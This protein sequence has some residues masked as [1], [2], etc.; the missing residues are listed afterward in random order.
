[1]GSQQFTTRNLRFYNA[2]EAIEQVWDWGWTYKSLH[3]GNC[4]VGLN[5]T[6]VNPAAQ[7]VGSIVLLDSF[8]ANTPTGIATSHDSKHWSVSNGSL[9]LEN[10][11]FENVQLAVQGTQGWTALPTNSGNLHV[12][13]WGIGHQYAE[14]GPQDFLGTLPAVS[15]IASLTAGSD[16]GSYYER[17]KP[18]YR[19]V[20]VSDFLSVKT[21]GAEGDGVTDDTEALQAV[22]DQAGS[23]E[24]H[25]AFFDAGTYRVTKTLRVPKVCRIVG[26]SYATIM[27]SGHFFANMTDP[28]AVVQV[29]SPSDVGKV[30]WSDMI[31][32]TQGSQAGAILIEWNVASTGQ[33]SGMWDVHTRIGGFAGSK[34]SVAECGASL[35]SSV[36]SSSGNNT[37]NRREAALGPKFNVGFPVYE[38]VATPT[39][40]ASLGSSAPQLSFTASQDLLQ[41][42]SAVSPDTLMSDS[43]VASVDAAPTID[44]A[45]S[46]YLP[47]QVTLAPLPSLAPIATPLATADLGSVAS[48]T[49]LSVS[50]PIV[51]ATASASPALLTPSSPSPDLSSPY[52]LTS[53][54]PLDDSSLPTNL[55]SNVSSIPSEACIGA[56]M[57][58]HITKSA[59][60]LYMENVW[61]WTADH[62]LDAPLQNI[63]VWSGRGLL[64]ESEKGDVWMYVLLADL[65]Y[66]C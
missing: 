38:G 22:L 52:N 50:T 5:M 60:G 20:P 33:P 40:L 10:V 62:D 56:F 41:P 26:E 53:Q 58:M 48:L 29:G 18:D 15:R 39:Y 44:S 57:S 4:T 36:G 47:P 8:F 51:D 66:W 45:P 6:N 55:T 2:V 59:S 37:I 28:Q 31:V 63:T 65:A 24:D 19:D 1:M 27:S 21:M 14:Q 32:S 9:I 46:S 23:N 54:Q 61:L 12:Q 42:S 25:V 11:G 17:S 64:I 13:A 3:V 16:N 7:N 49:S 43:P 34:S 35:P 30:E